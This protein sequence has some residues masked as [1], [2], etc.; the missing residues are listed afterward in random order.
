[1]NSCHLYLLPSLSCTFIYI[2]TIKENSQWSV[3][4][5]LQLLP[6]LKWQ[7]LLSLVDV[8]NPYP[9]HTIRIKKCS[10]PKSGMSF[11]WTRQHQLLMSLFISSL[12]NEI[13]P[14]VVGLS[15]S[16]DIWTTFEVSLALLP[17]YPYFQI[18]MRYNYKLS[19]RA[20][21]LSLNFYAKQSLF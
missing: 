17:I 1:M 5:L 16:Q 6:S 14:L 4:G 12:S 18:H 9:L 21:F 11:S 8:F 15:S 13:L 2:N 7:D 19:N 10:N 20:T 3:K